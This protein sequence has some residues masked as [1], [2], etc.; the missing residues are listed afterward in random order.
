MDVSLSKILQQFSNIPLQSL[1]TDRSKVSQSVGPIVF[2]EREREM[3]SGGWVVDC[4]SQ[5]CRLGRDADSVYTNDDF[6]VC[7][8]SYVRN[9]TEAAKLFKAGFK[10]ATNGKE[11]WP[12]LD[13]DFD[14]AQW[15]QEFDQVS[16]CV[17]FFLESTSNTSHAFR[18]W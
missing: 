7:S 3:S 18:F 14:L 16:A 1:L 6:K 4:G 11:E 15:T 9:W 17:F 12:Q 13:D 8:R 2:R 10:K 5:N